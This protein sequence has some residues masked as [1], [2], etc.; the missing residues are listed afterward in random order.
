MSGTLSGPKPQSERIFATFDDYHTLGKP[1][2]EHTSGNSVNDK[3][4]LI[5]R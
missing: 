4:R 1:A 3:R 5:R 2:F